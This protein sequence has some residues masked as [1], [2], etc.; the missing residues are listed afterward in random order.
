MLS[1]R[2]RVFV[3]VLLVY[4]AG[5]A[6]LMWRLLA[7]IDPRYRE[8]AEES[9]VETAQL[10]AALIEARSR[11][12]AAP[13]RS[14]SPPGG[15]PGEAGSAGL[16][17]YGL[18]TDGLNT[19]GLDT[20]FRELYA[21]RFEA[22]I[23][24]F[25]KTRVEL[26][27]YVTDRSGRVVFDSLGRHVGEDYSGWRDVRLTL[28]GKYGA[29]TSVDF[30]GPLDV[31]ASVM[32]VGAPIH[33]NDEIVGVASVGKPVQSF[34]QFV[35][36]A[37]R[38]TIVVG[39]TSVAAVVLL[40]VIVS[41]WLVRPYGILGIVRELWRY[42]RARRSLSLP[43]LAQRTRD[44][45]AASFDEMRDALAGRS[46]VAEHVQTLTHELKSPLSAIRG[47][48]E[49]LAEPQMPEADRQR[50]LAH[51]GRETARIQALIDRMMELSALESR[52]GL[53][54][55]EAV[56]LVPLLTELVEGANAA[57]A[58]RQVRVL[59]EHAQARDL[60]R[61]RAEADEP[62]VEGD[63]LL[64]RRAVGNL[65]DN[66]LDFSPQGGTVRVLLASARDTRG[67]GEAQVRLIDQGP[68]IPD[69]ADDKVF[70]KFYSLARPHS[71]KKGTG[72]GL[73]FVKEIAALHHG[74]VTLRNVGG[75]PGAGAEALLALPLA[76]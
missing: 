32:Y 1:R 42:A 39:A 71:Q 36:A 22:R 74:R 52:R 5:V 61:V 56:E 48:A 62:V 6:L 33:A 19:D 73:A 63:A 7:D 20:V 44:V 54:R 23:F 26:R 17:P 31:D 66:A 18:N 47:A 2:N 15:G 70:E 14:S 8:S 34:G 16:A 27:L 51:I 65:L 53:E 37:R 43:R 24:G 49:L 68:G 58:A 55:V 21:R 35:A 41:A 9:L 3:G 45:I 11:E 46:P 29:R 60:R 30:D 38:K 28:E 12:S 69:Y 75:A 10:V 40:V 4:A 57:G 25:E 72:L 50:F 67:R 59:F 64:L 13:A 76:R